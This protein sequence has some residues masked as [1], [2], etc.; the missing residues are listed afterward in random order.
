MRGPA[1]NQFA[2]VQS[3]ANGKSGKARTTSAGLI[4]LAEGLVFPE[5]PRWHGERLWVADL[6]ARR[7]VRIDLDGTVE[8]V[9]ELDDMPSGLG[10]LPDGTPIVVSMHKRQ[11]FSISDQRLRLHADLGGIGGDFLNDMVV[12]ARGRAYVGRRFNKPASGWGSIS[13][14]AIVLV[15]EDRSIRVV[16]ENLFGPNGT[17]ITPDH[18]TLIVAESHAGRLT[19][20]SIA[21]DGSLTDRRL[22]ATVD[23]I[24]DGICLDADG[25]I[26]VGLSKFAAFVRVREGGE[27]AERIELSG[28]RYAIACMLGGPGRLTLFLL[29]SIADAE[30][31][32][33]C[34]GSDRSCTARGFVEARPV[35]VPGVGLP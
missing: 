4:T 7:V 31:L 22:F 1:G 27:I 13:P 2:G 11:L 12:D 9:A 28:G 18:R 35:E 23:G 20:F 29:T 24:P 30:N 14:E 16:A 5:G 10:F 21:D 17:V 32:S 3:G 6:F 33:E 26:W 8:T 19:A 25:A 15:D 34:F